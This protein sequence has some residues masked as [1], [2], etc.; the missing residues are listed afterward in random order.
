MK[1]T[2]FISDVHLG[3][4]GDPAILLDYTAGIAAV[5]ELIDVPLIAGSTLR[6]GGD[7]VTGDR[8]SGA[9]GAVGISRHLTPRKNI[10]AGDLLVMTAGSGGGTIAATA[11]FHGQPSVLNETL[12]IDF[13]RF[14]K[15]LLGHPVIKGV[16]AMTDVTN[17]GIRGDLHEMVA[18]TDIDI[19]LQSGEFLS[20][21]NPT[22][23]TMLHSLSIDPYGVSID[24]L[25]VVCPHE[26]AMEVLDIMKMG[27]M[28]AG[29]VGRVEKG[30]GRV[31]MKG[32]NAGI[33]PREMKVQFREAPYTPVKEVVDKNPMD[34]EVVRKRME[35]AVT[36]SQ[37]KKEWLK[38]RIG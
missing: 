13:I 24:S 5:G 3:N 7:L 32:P 31:F 17:G 8:L 28:N 29:I 25:L 4:D 30:N 1:K 18:D 26:V 37:K 21:I 14:T 9:A 16:H 11:I 27:G 12:N 34:P 23:L 19:I 10:V 33:G 6:I 15:E 2:Y 20:L 38:D 36:N 35:D 22:V